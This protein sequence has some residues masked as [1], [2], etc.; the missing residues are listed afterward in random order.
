MKGSFNPLSII[1]DKRDGRVHS[2]VEIA[3]FIEEFTAGNVA[4]YQ[5]SA[6]LMASFLRGLNDE[7]TVALTDAMLRSGKVLAL[8]SVKAAK[9]DKHST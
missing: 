4:D 1:R 3:R 8:P 7:E 6:W 9:I 5:M 2:P